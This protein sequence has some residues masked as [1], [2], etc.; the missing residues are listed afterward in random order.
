MLAKAL[1]DSSH[2]YE[3]DSSI[4][5]ETDNTEIIVSEKT[6]E[7]LKWAIGWPILNWGHEQKLTNYQDKIYEESL[8][9]VRL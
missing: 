2:Q 1:F 3:I 6:D 5:F 8:I 9:K 4:L 7:I